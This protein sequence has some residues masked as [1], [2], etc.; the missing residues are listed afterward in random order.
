MFDVVVGEMKVPGR[1][2]FIIIKWGGT[3]TYLDLKRLTKFYQDITDHKI[4]IKVQ[5]QLNTSDK[6][7]YIFQ[8][9]NT[10]MHISVSGSKNKNSSLA[11]S[12]LM[13]MASSLKSTS[14]VVRISASVEDM[15][16]WLYRS[17]DEFSR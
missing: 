3:D 13:G 7:L 9:R 14:N 4:S 2:G 1:R 15:G 16:S 10:E 17:A 11:S 5:L 12:S 6:V 8:D